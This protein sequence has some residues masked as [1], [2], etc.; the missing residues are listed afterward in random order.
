MAVLG[1]G[2]GGMVCTAQMCNNHD[3]AFDPEFR[4]HREARAA[5]P[6]CSGDGKHALI[7]PMT[8]NAAAE[9][10]LLAVICCLG[11][12]GAYSAAMWLE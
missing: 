10:G 7:Q 4:H 2:E 5:R 12:I 11:L 1:G 3:R 6:A 9:M 8:M